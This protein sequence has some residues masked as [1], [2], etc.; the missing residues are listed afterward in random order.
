MVEESRPN[1][2]VMR[3]LQTMPKSVYHCTRR[4]MPDLSN[5]PGH[6]A[7]QRGFVL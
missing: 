2:T 3:M 5:L 1:S 6:F 4:S 7:L